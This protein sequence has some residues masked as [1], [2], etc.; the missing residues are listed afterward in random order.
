MMW[1]DDCIVQQAVSFPYDYIVVE[2]CKVRELFDIKVCG[3]MKYMRRISGNGRVSLAVMEDT[4]VNRTVD[5]F[6]YEPDY[7]Q[8]YNGH[9]AVNRS[10][11]FPLMLN[12]RAEFREK[13][14]RL[15]VVPMK[16]YGGDDISSHFD[17]IASWGFNAVRVCLDVMDETIYEL[18]L[19]VVTHIIIHLIKDF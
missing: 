17:T 3:F 19:F 5:D 2:D 12:Y 13:D 10:E 8:L 4:V 1:L 14:G 9:F 11:W 15:R 7:V 16:Y 6:F 18:L